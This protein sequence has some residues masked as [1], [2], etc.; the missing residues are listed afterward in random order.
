M[1]FEVV[2]LEMLKVDQFYRNEVNK[3]Q[4]NNINYKA[5]FASLVNIASHWS[6]ASSGTN[7]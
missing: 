3:S 6:S 5:V 1:E 4:T 7:K 2:Y